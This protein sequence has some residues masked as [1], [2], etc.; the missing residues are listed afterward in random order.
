MTNGITSLISYSMVVTAAKTQTAGSPF[1]GL[2]SAKD[3]D[4]LQVGTKD[5]Q[6]VLRGNLL[7]GRSGIDNGRISCTSDICCMTHS[8][9]SKCSCSHGE[10]K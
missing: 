3:R 2:T 9:V 6:R 1:L 5:F 8:A 4:F 10:E 7:L